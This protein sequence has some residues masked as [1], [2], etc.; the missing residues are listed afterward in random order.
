MSAMCS[1]KNSPT[2]TDILSIFKLFIRIRNFKTDTNKKAPCPGAFFLYA[3]AVSSAGAAS[4]FAAAL[5]FVS[6][7]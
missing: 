5:C 1:V 4:A 7:F 6:V 2:I 3:V